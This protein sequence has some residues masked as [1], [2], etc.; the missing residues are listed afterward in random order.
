VNFSTG[1]DVL[2]DIDNL[3]AQAS[4]LD[5]QDRRLLSMIESLKE[6]QALSQRGGAAFLVLLIPSKEEIYG[7]PFVPE[8][9]KPEQTLEQRLKEEGFSVLSTYEAIR[10]KAKDQS[11]FFSHDIHLTA[12][13]NQIVSDSVVDWV[14]HAST[15][16]A[17][18]K[19]VASKEP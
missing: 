15:S 16:S 4:G 12:L 8:V 1:P 13:G 7:A 2:L 9:M 19:P 3:R 14:K 17:E 11:A 10:D 5:R 6:M 18:K